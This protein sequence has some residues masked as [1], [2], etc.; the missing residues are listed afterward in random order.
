MY[1]LNSHNVSCHL[2]LSKAGQCLTF[3]INYSNLLFSY[4]RPISLVLRNV[5]ATGQ[6]LVPFFLSS[7]LCQI[8]N[9]IPTVKKKKPVNLQTGFCCL[10]Q[11][12]LKPTLS[13]FI[14]MPTNQET[15][16]MG[17]AVFSSKEEQKLWI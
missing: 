6:I 10:H 2:Y 4:T 13:K 8:S 15:A 17:H 1:T 16:I 7:V 5:P 9:T 14:K 3:T 12:L 11:F